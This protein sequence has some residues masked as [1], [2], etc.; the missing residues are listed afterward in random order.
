MKPGTRPKPS[1]L[2]LID[3]DAGHRPPNQNEAKPKSAIPPCPAHLKP[4]AKKEWRR[5]SKRLLTLGL[6]THIDRA[7][8]AMYCQAW[9]RWVE[10]EEKVAE[11]P[12]K[13]IVKTK[14]GNII[15]NPYL[16]IANRAQDHLLK[17]AAEFGMTPSSRT[18]AVAETSEKSNSFAKHRNRG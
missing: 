12:G 18:R 6:L 5:I 16:A 17:C 2:R 7:V 13:D 4:H 15:Q 10:A 9:A 3:G 1:A 14:G 11:M 8:L